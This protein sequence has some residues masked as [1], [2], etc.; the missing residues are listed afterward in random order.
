MFNANKLLY[1]IVSSFDLEVIKL[2]HIQFGTRV[3]KQ[4]IIALY[5]ESKYVLKFYN[6]EARSLPSFLPSFGDD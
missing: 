5:F 6:R 1:C 4:A 3:H 2:G